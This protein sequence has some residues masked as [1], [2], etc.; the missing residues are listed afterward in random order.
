[1]DAKTVERYFKDLYGTDM[2]NNVSDE[3]DRGIFKDSETIYLTP[4]EIIDL[5]QDIERREC[6]Q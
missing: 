5:L 3:I 4:S 1:M 2:Y 6:V